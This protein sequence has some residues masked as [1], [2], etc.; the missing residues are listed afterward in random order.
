MTGHVVPVPSGFFIEW[1]NGPDVFGANF[2]AGC[3]AK[4]EVAIF[5]ESA[6]SVAREGFIGLLRLSSVLAFSRER[7]PG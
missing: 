6:R 1:P 2:A 3:F 4:P 7:G 5:D